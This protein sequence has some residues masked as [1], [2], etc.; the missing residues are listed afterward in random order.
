MCVKP[1][2]RIRSFSRRNQNKNA[3]LY[4][5]WM[6]VTPSDILLFDYLLS[7][8]ESSHDDMSRSSSFQ[9]HT[10]ATVGEYGLR[11]YRNMES[12]NHSGRSE[13]LDGR[14]SPEDQEK[15]PQETER[16]LESFFD[17][18]CTRNDSDD[19]E[20]YQHTHYLTAGSSQLQFGKDPG[21]D[22]IQDERIIV[23]EDVVQIC[24]YIAMLIKLLPVVRATNNSDDRDE[25]YH[26]HHCSHHCI[27]LPFGNA[28][29]NYDV[30]NEGM[31]APEDDQK[32]SETIERFPESFSV[33]HA[34]QTNLYDRDEYSRTDF[35]NSTSI[36]LH[37]ENDPEG[38][39]FLDER[40]VTPEDEEQ[41][42]DARTIEFQ[43]LLFYCNQIHLDERDE[44]YYPDPPYTQHI[45]LS[46]TYHLLQDIPRLAN[47]RIYSKP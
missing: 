18:H 28:P 24:D 9:D 11:Q 32:A 12:G 25:Y 4:L 33:E 47:P 2:I 46:R 21:R 36:Q 26:I 42:P 15:V 13:M 30:R 44:Y 22:H 7:L 39:E 29:T 31:I 5:A 16:F 38:D 23:R 43:T 37:P 6:F 34:Y 20:A 19:I 10:N 8:G 1:E 27:Q 3:T 40:V 45:Q 41:E 14:T 17:N 35:R